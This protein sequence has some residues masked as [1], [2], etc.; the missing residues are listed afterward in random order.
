MIQTNDNFNGLK[1]TKNLSDSTHTPKLF[2]FFSMLPNTKSTIC[3]HFSGANYIKSLYIANR[4][5][6]FYLYII[7]QFA[8]DLILEGI[9]E[10]FYATII[11]DSIP[12][13][14]RCLLLNI[15]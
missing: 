15:I 3:S 1:L 9:I 4:S 5:L 8:L 6:G 13:I 7:N 10:N 14:T 11:S 2:L 12:L